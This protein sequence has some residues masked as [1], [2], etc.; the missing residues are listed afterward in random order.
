M[1]YIKKKLLAPLLFSSFLTSLSYGAV[2]EESDLNIQSI[3]HCRPTGMPT[4]VINEDNTV[5]VRPAYISE[6]I[7][8]KPNEEPP[9]EAF[10]SPSQHKKEVEDF[11]IRMMQLVDAGKECD[12]IAIKYIA[13]F[14]HYFCPASSIYK[15]LELNAKGVVDQFFNNFN[16]PIFQEAK[17]VSRCKLTGD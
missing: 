4:E 1:V 9:Y 14:Y 6:W 10:K 12:P 13:R 17:K 16:E 15:D 8:I 2:V 11:A 5:T 3:P 7:G